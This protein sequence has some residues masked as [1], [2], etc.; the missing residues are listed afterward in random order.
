MYCYRG[1]QKNKFPELGTS[2]CFCPEALPCWSLSPESMLLFHGQGLSWLPVN[3]VTHLEK[4]SSCTY[5][6][7]CHFVYS[8]ERT[9][10]Q[11]C[12]YLC[13]L[14]APRALPLAPLGH[15]NARQKHAKRRLQTIWKHFQIIIL[16]SFWQSSIN[17]NPCKA[18]NENQTTNC[19]A[20]IFTGKKN[21]N[22]ACTSR[23]PWISLG[24]D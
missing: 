14:P 22:P 18:D 21:K 7:I 23:M 20:G 24:I 8:S 3:S 10:Y 1:S 4:E 19:Q 9:L 12:S 17:H 13:S 5:S 2:S 16:K 15:S 6:N 11:L